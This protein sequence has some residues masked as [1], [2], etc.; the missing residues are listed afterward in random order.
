[1]SAAFLTKVEIDHETAYMAGLRDSYA[2]HKR[3]WEMFP[4]RGDQTRD[5]LTRLDGID[6]GFRLLV[7]SAT[8]PRRPNWCPEPAW[9]SKTLPDSFLEHSQFR[10]SLIANPTRKVK[11]ENN[12]KNGRRLPIT[13]REDREID[14]KSTPACSLG[15]AA[16]VNSTAFPSTTPPS[17]LSPNP[18]SGSLKKVPPE[19]TVRPSLSARSPSPIPRNSAPPSRKAW[20]AQKPSAS[21]CYAS[22]QLNDSRK[23][24]INRQTQT[25]KHQRP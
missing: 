3:V 12:T 5:F 17:A 24:T 4:G 10:F 13:H 9:H 2:W 8:E 22:A 18:A 1:M 20:A 14:G 25:T 23:P 19:S 21:E 15:S 11:S 16:R 7:V 6:G